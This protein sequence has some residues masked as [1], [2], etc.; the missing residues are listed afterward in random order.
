MLLVVV[1]FPNWPELLYPQV[2]RV[3]SEQSTRLLS[4][5]VVIATTILFAS[6][7]LRSTRTGTLLPVVLLLPNWPLLL[8]PHVASVPSAQSARLK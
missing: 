8:A 5:A 4:P 3:P 2:A 1:L 6:A 7:P